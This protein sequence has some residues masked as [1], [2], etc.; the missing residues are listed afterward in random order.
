[1]RRPRIL[2]ATIV[3]AP[4]LA[5]G[6]YEYVPATP[7]APAPGQFVRADVTDQAASRLTSLLGPGI[8][9]V[10]G[11]VLRQEDAAVAILVDSYSTARNGDLSANND[12]VL[13]PFQEIRA[14][15]VKQLSKKRSVIFGAA[16]IGGAVISAAVFTDLGRQLRNEDGDGDPQP[17]LRSGPRLRL[18]L[19]LRIPVPRL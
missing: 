19:G 5:G 2:H 8:I 9:Q 3:V 10:H 18:P 7:A 11:M 6:C 17:E 4:L 13:L 12:P 14:L 16:F 15:S 1:V